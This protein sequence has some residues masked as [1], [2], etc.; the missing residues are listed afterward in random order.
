VK[1]VKGIG[2]EFDGRGLTSQN[3]FAAAVSD[4]TRS[5]SSVEHM[6]VLPVTELRGNSAGVAARAADI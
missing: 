1:N 3:V 2:F 4:S 5:C 6:P